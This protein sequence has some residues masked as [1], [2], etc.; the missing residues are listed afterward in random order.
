MHPLVSV[1]IPTYNA[2][3]HIQ[4]CVR[5]VLEQ[6]YPSDKT[7]IIIADN[8]SDDNTTGKAQELADNIIVTKEC[9]YT[10]SPYSARNRGIEASGGEVIV[11]LDSDCVPEKQWLSRGTEALL[12]QKADVVGGGVVFRLDETATFGEMYDAI[13]NIRMKASVEQH[14]MAKTVNLFIKRSVFTDIG[15]FPEGWRSGGDVFWTR[16]LTAAGKQLVY[17]D[18]A[19]VYKPPR[20]LK[21]LLKKQ[22]RVATAQP[23]V[24][25]RQ[26]EYLTLLIHLAKIAIPP[27][28]IRNNIKENGKP[29]MTR[30]VYRLFLL[31]LIV[32][33][34]MILGNISGVFQYLF[35][36]RKHNAS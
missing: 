5:S 17:C 8:C 12:A 22:W 9:K 19:R 29:F 13:M 32:R 30:Y 35:S 7:E 31:S 15:L 25:L 33:P 1:I 14:R 36:T 16:S 3:K 23:R 27:R 28:T 18:S 21:G 20:K 10:G 24:W 34:V 26:K 2:E 4:R 6:D 11:L